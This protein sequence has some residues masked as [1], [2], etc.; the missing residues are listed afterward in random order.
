MKICSTISVQPKYRSTNAFNQL[1]GIRRSYL[2]DRIL[3]LNLWYR[4]SLK[5]EKSNRGYQSANHPHHTNQRWTCNVNQLQNIKLHDW[6]AI[7]FIDYIVCQWQRDNELIWPNSN[8]SGAQRLQK[9]FLNK[10][11]LNDKKSIRDNTRT[12]VNENTL[13]KR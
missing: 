13:A 11:P 5:R 10:G 1:I 12:R 6:K 8:P 4:I 9:P 7:I 2:A 3:S